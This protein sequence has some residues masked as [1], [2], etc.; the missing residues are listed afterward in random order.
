[1]KRNFYLTHVY[2][3]CLWALML[4]ICPLSL[5]ASSIKK[6]V[7]PISKTEFKI[8]GKVVDIF[9]EYEKQQKAYQTLLKEALPNNYIKTEGLERHLY[10]EQPKW[11]KTYKIAKLKGFYS[12]C[13]NEARTQLGIIYYKFKVKYIYEFALQGDT[14]VPKAIKNKSACMRNEIMKI[15][16]DYTIIPVNKDEKQNIERLTNL[17]HSYNV[18][19]MEVRKLFR[20]IL[21]D[22]RLGKTHYGYESFQIIGL[23]YDNHAV[24]IANHYVGNRADVYGPNLGLPAVFSQYADF[25]S[26]Q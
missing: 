7:K 6:Y 10:V 8:N 23:D 22:A 24:L 13:L 5:G 26:V 15:S 2:T 9:K 21:V 3:T 14:W 16:T 20:Q 25:W 19:K 12:I 11:K 1:M 4:F 17:G 18:A